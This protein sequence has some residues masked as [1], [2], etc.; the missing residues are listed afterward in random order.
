MRWRAAMLNGA[1]GIWLG[2]WRHPCGSLSTRTLASQAFGRA[3]A[4]FQ[5]HEGDDRRLP[6]GTL[7][8]NE[9]CSF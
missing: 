7:D 9:A 5:E 2:L 4:W 3:Q 6:A 1:R 8:T